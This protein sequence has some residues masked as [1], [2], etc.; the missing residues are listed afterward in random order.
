MYVYTTTQHIYM[1]K[2][3]WSPQPESEPHSLFSLKNNFRVKSTQKIQ[4]S[5]MK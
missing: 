4:L 2:R 1:R 3:N 5:S